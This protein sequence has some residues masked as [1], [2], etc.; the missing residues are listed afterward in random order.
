MN[1]S[2]KSWGGYSTHTLPT[3]NADTS[4]EDESNIHFLLNI[5]EDI[6]K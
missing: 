3:R 5:Y 4:L 6:E 1:S 2:E